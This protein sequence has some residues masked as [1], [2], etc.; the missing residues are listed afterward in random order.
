ML[1]PMDALAR[2]FG[3][4]ARRV[5]HVGAHLGEEA[6]AYHDAGAE[7]ALW[8]EANPELMDD[9]RA[10]LAPFPGQTALRA[11]VTELDGGWA[12][13]HVA[14][15]ATAAAPTMSSSLLEPTA[16]RAI[17]PF[18][19]YSKTLAMATTTLDAL[20]AREG[21]APGRFDFLNLDVEG[22]ELRV[23]RGAEATLKGV[24]WV[25]TEVNHVERFAGGAVL[26]AMDDH[27]GER[28]FLRVALRDFPDGTWG[29]A[30]YA[31]RGPADA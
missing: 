19:D 23:L 6:E 17:Y 2:D 27:L 9:L 5:L 15:S 20:L 18:F 1:I 28:G 8:V 4:R 30:L 22:G 29:D 14:Q 31:R 10:A 3:V 21:Y 11:A 12:T 16:Q 25:F 7:E 13:L 26:P 24:R